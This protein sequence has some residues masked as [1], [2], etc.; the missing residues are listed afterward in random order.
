MQEKTA[1]KIKNIYPKL[2]LFRL[3]LRT[4]DSIIKIYH[5]TEEKYEYVFQQLE[6]MEL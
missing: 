4:L 6:A 5:F 1:S 3:H 2:S